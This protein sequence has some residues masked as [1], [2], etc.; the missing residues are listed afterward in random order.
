M[1]T[2][3][4]DDPRPG[5]RRR[6][7]RRLAVAGTAPPTGRPIPGPAPRPADRS[8]TARALLPIEKTL[9]TEGDAAALDVAFIDQALRRLATRTGPGR[10]ADASRGSRRTSPTIC[11]CTSPNRPTCPQPWQQAPDR[12]RWQIPTTIDLDQIGPLDPGVARPL[13]AT[14]HPRHRRPRP[15]VA[16]QPRRSRRHPPHRRPR[17]G[18]RLRPPP[19]RRTRRPPLG[20]STYR[21]NASASPREAVALNPR[22]VR[23]HDTPATSTTSPPSSPTPSP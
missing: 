23:H 4:V 10:P 18:P 5:R 1:T 11:G 15:P 20:Q 19:R 16:V 6:A 14:G 17:P 9:R 2:P 22:R 3:G 12:L 8:P 13:P 21:S 7:P